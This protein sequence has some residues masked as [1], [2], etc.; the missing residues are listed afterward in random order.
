[1]LTA[2]NKV[3]IPGVF[4]QVQS[5]AIYPAMGHMARDCNRRISSVLNHRASH[6][7]DSSTMDAAPTTATSSTAPSPV[8]SFFHH[9]DDFFHT[10][11]FSNSLQ[12]MPLLKKM[13][14][15]DDMRRKHYF[16]T[17]E[18]KAEDDKVSISLDLPGLKLDDIKVEIIDKVL[19][20]SGERN[21]WSDNGF[22]SEIKFDKQFTFD[23]TVNTAEIIANLAGGVLRVTLPKLPKTESPPVNTRTIH[24]TSINP[25]LE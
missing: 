24:I 21:I 18:I 3:T 7:H 1:M 23:E 25:G 14:W 22:S 5:P 17:Y 12:P 4:R 20:I 6:P 13:D 8:S 19:H 10:P 11:L 15:V 9:V 16:P 2:L